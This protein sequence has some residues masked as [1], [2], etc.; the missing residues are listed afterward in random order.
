MA[1]ERGRRDRKCREVESSTTNPPRPLLALTLI[2]TTTLETRHQAL[3]DA[4]DEIARQFP[5]CSQISRA[6][7][8][9][10]GSMRSI[11]RIMN[12]C[13]PVNA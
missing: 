4:D 1:I 13:S 6:I 2:K 3:F 12:L 11:T 5:L 8:R 7:I 9:P 10:S